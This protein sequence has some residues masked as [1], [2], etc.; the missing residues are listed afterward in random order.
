[1]FPRRPFSRRKKPL[2]HRIET[3]PRHLSI[4]PLE[5]RRL[6][7]AGQWQAIIAG[8]APAATL[9]QQTVLG[10][11]LFHAYNIADANAQVVRALDLSGT[12][13]VQTPDTATQGDVT[14]EL[15]GVPGFRLVEEY[16]VDTGTPE[17]DDTGDGDLINFDY[18]K[19][20]QAFGPDQPRVSPPQISTAASGV[21]SNVL[22][23]NDNGATTAGYFTQSETTIIAAGNN[24]VVGFNDSGSNDTGSGGGQFTG[25]AYSTNGGTSF[26]DGGLL[27]ANTNG[28]A[29][30]PVMARDSTTGRIYFATL[31]F[32]NYGVDVFY[33]DNNGA[34]WSGPV[35]GAPGKQTAGALQ[36][37]E[38]IA[39]DN[40]NGGGNGN[41]YLV[42]R[43]FGTGNGI[44]FFRSTDH[45][46]TYGP[47]GGT[48][49]S[50][51]TNCQGAF[52]AVGPDHSVYVFWY[53]GSSALHMRKS[54]DQGQ[55]FG[56]TITVGSITSTGTNGDLGLT[57]IDH[58][59]TGASTIRSNTFP[60]VA[61]SPTTGQIFVAYSDKGTATGDK[62]D[63]YMVT[64]TNGGTSW[65]ARTKINDD[66]TTTDQWQ[67][68][69]AITP[70]GSKLGIFY[71]SRQGDTTSDNLFQYYGRVGTISGTTVTFTPSFAV[72]TVQS[73]PEVGRDSVIN[74]TYM[75]DYDTSVGLPAAFDV[76]WAD[77]RSALPGSST[78]MD[79]NVYFSQ[80][81]L[82]LGVTGTTPAANSV[83]STQ[84]VTYTVSTSDTVDPATITA[85]GFLV[86]GIPANSFAYTPG[87]TT[88]TYT[89]NTSPVTAQGLQT[90]HIN[91]GAFNRASDE[92]PVSSY[93]A[94]FRYDTIL[95]AVTSTTPA[96]NGAF[97]LPG[98]FA[99]TVNFN[100]P[101]NPATVT[102]STLTLSGVAGA[103]ATGVTLSNGNTTAQFTLGNITTAGMLNVSIAA[104]AVTDVYGNPGAAFSANYYVDVG[105]QPFPVP[106]VST[107]P[108]GSLVYSNSTS[109]G[110]INA[111]NS[112]D[113]FTLS[114]N[115]SQTISVLVTPTSSTF[116]PSVQLVDP[117]GT[118]I[119]TA[120]AAAVNQNALLQ[121][122]ATTSASTGTYKIVVSGASSTTGGYT[123]QV[124]L[125]AALEQEGRIA[126]ASNNTIATAQ[127]LTGAFSSVTATVPSVQRAAVLGQTDPAAG[128][129]ATI[130]TYAFQ[131]IAT[132]GTTITGLSG[133][134]D[135]S[136]LISPTGITFPFFGTNY[137]S[138]YVSSNGLISFGVSDSSFTNADFTS[139]P[140]EAAIAPFWDD[141]YVTGAADSKV[142]Y[143]VIGS[144][145]SA[146]LVIQWNDISYF[147][148]STRSGGLTFEAILGADGSI[149]FNYQSVTTG[150]NSGG[151]SGLSAT[152]AIKAAGT[153]GSNRL[154]LAYNGTPTGWNNYVKNLNSVLITNN[155]G[156]GDYYSFNVSSPETDTFTLANVTSGAITLSL[157]NSGGT[158]LASGVSGA[159]NLAQIISNYNFLTAA[160]YYLYVAGT[161]NVTY[162]LGIVRGA[163]F[164][165]EPNNTLATAENISGTGGALSALTS[166]TDVDWYSVSAN[167]GGVLTVATSIP[168]AGTGQFVDALYPHI[169]L[170]DPTGT[171]LLANGTVGG[172]GRNETLGYAVT[173][174]GAY[175]I[176]VTGKNSTQGEYYLDLAHHLVLAVPANMT[177]GDPPATAMLTIPAPL[178]S[179]L[180][181]ALNASDATRLSVP[182]SETIPA[183]Q[184]SVSFQIS[185][186]VDNLLDGPEQITISAVGSG[187]YATSAV[188]TVH[189]N[190]SATITATLP[191]SAHEFAGTVQGTITSSTAPSQNITIQLASSDTTRLTV[192]ATVI[193]PA[194]LTSVNFTA[195]LL[196]DHV[197]EGGPTP[198]SVSPQM[199]NWPTV[200]ATISIL[201][202][203]A[204]IAVSLPGSAWE[205]QT[206]AGTVT[207]GGTLTTPLT[208]NL[209]SGDTTLL[210]LPATV[211]IPAGQTTAGFTATL[212]DNGVHE[213]PKPVTVTASAS[214][215]TTGTT[216]IT[217]DDA[218]VDHYTFGTVPANV[219][220]GTAFTTT[221]TAYDVANNQIT[222]YNATV[223]LTAMG[224]G[225][226]LA[227]SP[228][229]I[230]F[231]SGAWTGSITI[232]T[233]DPAA[234]LKLNNGLSAL[235]SSSPINVYQQL[236]V[237][238]TNPPAGG[239]MTVGATTTL[240]VTFNE[241]IM[242]SSI[243][244]SSLVLSGISGAAVGGV[245]VQPGNTAAQ[246][247]LTGIT[248]EGTL[249]AS[250]AA[251]AV[252]DQFGYPI[253]AFS[254]TYYPNIPISAFPVPLTAV[255]PLGSLVYQ[256]SASAIIAPAGDTDSYTIS[257]DAGQSLTAFVVP[258]ATLQPSVS[259]TAPN[260]TVLGTATASALG[261]QAVLQSVPV[262]AAGTYTI[263]VSG[264]AGT[265]AFT[266]QLEL[267][268]AV[269]SEAHGG[270]TNNTFAA[271]Q[272]LDAAF[273]SLGTASQRA[274]VLGTTDGG[275]SQTFVSF[276]L[277]TDPGWSYQGQWAFGTPTGG[278]G[279]SYGNHDPT[280]GHTGS[281]VIGVNLAGDY[282][283]TVGG[284]WYV[285][286]SAI[287]C[288]G[289]TNVQLSFWRWLN[290]DYPPYVTDTIDVSNNGTAWTNVF[291]NT[292]GVPITD[293]S[294]QLMQYDIHAVAD[295]QP[296]VYIRWGYA[297][298]A[299]AF[300]YSGWNIDDVSL[301]A[302]APLTSDYYSMTLAAGQPVTAGLTSLA[303]DNTTLNLYNSAQ[304]L[305][306]T[307][308]SGATNL[309]E[310]IS[311]YVP[312]I[313]GT[314]YLQVAGNG[315]PYDLVVTLNAALATLPNG[316][317][318]TA[319]NITGTSG[320]LG[321]VQAATST[322]N[323]VVPNA[324]A[325]VSG[326]ASN[327][328]PFNLGQFSLPS[329][330]YQQIYSHTQFATG[331]AIDAIRFRR[332][333]GASTFST[334]GIN[335]RIDLGYAATTVSTISGTFASNRGNGMV[336]VF[337][338]VL[339]LSSTG[340]GTPNP[341]DIVINVPPS[342]NYIPAQGDLLMDVFMRNAPI[343]AQFDAASSSSVMSRAYSTSTVNDAS[344]SVDQIGLITRFDF[345]PSASAAWY[346][347]NVP[348]AGGTVNLVTSTPSDGPGEFVNTLS[349]H[350]Q[351]YD[352]TGTT[353][354]ANG[355]VLNDGR[356]ET[357][358]YAV[359]TAGAYKIEVT[360]K[361]NT[362]GEYFLKT[363]Q[364]SVV[365]RYVFYNNSYFDGNDPTANAQDDA[366]IA[367]DKTALLPGGT[368]SFT[369][370][371][372]Y[373]RGINGI[374]MD[375]QNLT[376]TPTNAD[377]AFKVGNSNSPGAWAAAPAPTSVTVRP[378][379][380][381]G[382]STRIE[383][384]WPDGA[385]NK[386]WLRVTLLADAATGLAANDVFFFGNAVGDTGNSPTDAYVN[387]NDEIL[388]RHNSTTAASITNVEDFDRSGAVD[389]ND[390]AIVRQNGTN[391][392]T[393]L[394]LITVPMTPSASEVAPGATL[395][396]LTT[397]AATSVFGMPP[398][399][400]AVVTAVNSSVTPTGQVDFVDSTTGA[401]LGLALLDATGQAVLPTPV[402]AVG[403]HGIIA[404][405]SGDANFGVS[406]STPSTVTVLG[407][408]TW[409]GGG[410]D[411]NW[412]TAANWGGISLA[413][414]MPLS[415]TGAGGPATNDVTAMQ[416][417]GIAFP[418][419][420]GPFVLS[421][422]PV[423]LSGAISNAS[424]ATQTV[425]LPL[426]LISSDAVL[427]SDGAVL[428]ITGDI[429][430]SGAYGIQKTGAGTVVLSGNNTYSGDT[431]VA[432]GKLVITS[433]TALPAGGDITIG[434]W[435][436]SIMNSGQSG[437]AAPDATGQL[438]ASPVPAPAHTTAATAVTSA[439]DVDAA[440]PLPSPSIPLQ[441]KVSAA[442]QIFAS[443]ATTSPNPVGSVAGARAAAAV[444]ADSLQA[445][446]DSNGDGVFAHLQ[447][448]DAVLADWQ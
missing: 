348:A 244:T 68:S 273:T 70:D 268:A 65:S 94:T 411:S 434:N 422:N 448:C 196:N 116:Q 228:T 252:L 186:I 119:G 17:A 193:L 201:D 304:G 218:D 220:V 249:T 156:T 75:G 375:V 309:N 248:S 169:Q 207:I 5:V 12:F 429:S 96:A 237:A 151:D 74:T 292:A 191:L 152:A 328:Y 279:T 39:V 230:T 76:V 386:E 438:A 99:Y 44:Y 32:T 115:P 331:G 176:Q 81:S 157:Y 202:D 402:L 90:L 235:G 198:V 418:D 296:T 391:F 352:P 149:R 118:I 340:A 122:V 424:S 398:A 173:T 413:S 280:S 238:S 27:P 222:V 102:T 33:S 368:A 139:S 229:S 442:D 307:G 1:M 439:A 37:K 362:Q 257:L 15:Q 194:G 142:L 408:A 400:V 313:P 87:S 128:Y 111:D 129:S 110:F 409:Y 163:A 2:S 158:L 365:G 383:V 121:S 63:I 271:A 126:G 345:V 264:A 143:Q 384:I 180:V 160:T 19:E 300:P 79:P 428:N 243:S 190:Q 203:D 61:I 60:S 263:T 217:V 114:V 138:M 277:N 72:S 441:P 227:V 210:T 318:A 287:N 188:V 315:A 97:A 78:L 326:N 420:S 246:F 49:I 262:T 43:D 446:T 417:G 85:S 259:I 314:Y 285:T 350:I 410:A 225:G 310:V 77:N 297:V 179:D 347:V 378:G 374:M 251:G 349:P 415:F 323:I 387:A 113:T 389:S 282:S 330:R 112:P 266:L 405:Y 253:Q 47:S 134:D 430:S 226:S 443:M 306:A 267:N 358:S 46:Q 242:P 34:S 342:F 13:L 370:Y 98:P 80:V 52:V 29:G 185:A 7:V 421:G 239:V 4:E 171:T 231:A 131:N 166:S 324:D 66:T 141:L 447:A 399:L 83:V 404:E 289:R 329:L 355:T 303:T 159:T 136:V 416:V 369:N 55:T 293:S 41:V 57:G 36:D 172:D 382:G 133:Q 192:P 250:I 321:S 444:L 224:A 346:S 360:S 388:T 123:V 187:G 372:S 170:Y 295:N 155:P 394:K 327:G 109:I 8:M 357:L 312:S 261:Q 213:G 291:T 54:T 427:N 212:P 367:T 351:L 381:A 206:A 283:T 144:G 301:S 177:E 269:E 95:L 175:K 195:T 401:D 132:T 258:A 67:P 10:Q 82:G 164:E 419:E 147:G 189:D 59:N 255:N 236:L 354:L 377:F 406:T 339:S 290:S 165:T 233:A 45:G 181:V 325:T 135:A 9:D 91:A 336:T 353:L 38:W 317:A 104:G 265:G 241:P 311:N 146:Q 6:L 92:S 332:A 276:P 373:S 120:T 281:N 395:T 204:T 254:G 298:A 64:S 28:D 167:A 93:D 436:S 197:I 219:P 385:I 392:M 153:Q 23:N 101:V 106:L 414:G 105:T 51:E 71:Y 69:I 88:I 333:A 432:E 208:V 221:V 148:D 168:S 294:W 379:A 316:T 162:N 145:T 363:F 270:P 437:A 403:T 117:N 3:K 334:S 366:A 445:S 288:T 344:G 211:T 199:D 435:D 31:Q 182:A 284:P 308:V 425:A 130:P 275:G 299:G 319:Q 127:N 278:G 84:P 260:S 433:A 337:D 426:T 124:Y 234:V 50:T 397:S 364:S 274:A 26:T 245:T 393:A 100:E 361:N 376:G 215:L 423:S 42:E 205:G 125:N 431:A 56:S 209:A 256:G 89:F 440:A 108:V 232:N 272:P 22:V 178:T 21:G 343:T 62:G 40:N 73:Y 86:N 140:S 154:L 322:A 286:T 223:P 320:V 359:T 48:V 11:N 338:G 247:T 25:F 184:T 14:S 137:T 305:V 335:V 183:G 30:D 200:P 216:S 35:Q 18:I 107:A 341:F 412:S 396:V 371:T 58:G 150:H 407:S 240:T 20:Q 16:A 390:V 103:I 161:A 356:N 214:G 53:S 24:V 302:T 380:G 174:A